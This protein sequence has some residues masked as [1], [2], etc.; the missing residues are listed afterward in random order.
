MGNKD[1]SVSDR[2]AITRFM[3]STVQNN[4]HA[5]IKNYLATGK[6]AEKLT[7][8]GREDTGV[9]NYEHQA[10]GLGWSA[11]HA[12]LNAEVYLP[13]LYRAEDALQT[14]VDNGKGDV[15]R[16][17]KLTEIRDE[18]VAKLRVKYTMQ[19]RQ[20]EAA[21]RLASEVQNIGVITSEEQALAED[22]IQFARGDSSD[23]GVIADGKHFL[24]DHGVVVALPV[25]EVSDLEIQDE[26]AAIASAPTGG[27]VVDFLR[28][29]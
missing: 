21:R 23:L 14:L 12:K 18:V 10:S 1:I 5:Q 24:S 6:F 16:G 7:E 11:A 22:L 29:A 17:I 4:L 27:V 3:I 8:D 28:A 15:A 19:P 13:I 20:R 9:Y 26:V 2:L 25:H